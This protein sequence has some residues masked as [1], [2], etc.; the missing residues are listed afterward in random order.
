[1]GQG[2][3]QEVSGRSMPSLEEKRVIRTEV[4]AKLM[5]SLDSG[6]ILK[7]SQ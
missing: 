4:V 2:Y 6:Y 3:K 7:V 5:E 1:M